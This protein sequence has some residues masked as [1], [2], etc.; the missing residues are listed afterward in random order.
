MTFVS[1][2]QECV[3]GLWG[4]FAWPELGFLTVGVLTGALVGI[5]PG[6]GGAATLAIFLPFSFSLPPTQMFALLLGVAA[7]ASTT[8]DLTSILVGIPGEATAAATVVDG[9]PMTL[10]GEAGR[11]IGASLVSSFTGSIVG[12]L[13]LA[14]MVPLALDVARAIGSPELFMLALL[15][16]SF[17]AAISP[18]T[19]LQG[20]AVGGLGLML[21]TVGL[22]RIGATPRFTFGQLFLWDGVGPI[23]VALGLLAIPEIVGM[24]SGFSA[25]PVTP[26]AAGSRLS[27]GTADARRLWP[28]VLQSSVIGTVI[29]LLPGVGAGV[30]QW[31]AYGYAAR[32]GT[33]GT[34]FG[35][36]AVEGV[37]APSAAN[38][39][40]LGAS[41][42]PALALGIPGGL[43]S[44]ILVG[45]LILKGL[46]PGP[47]M[48]LPSNQGGQLTLVFTLVWLIV[49]GNIIAVTLAYLSSKWL[50]K[51]AQVL[52]VTLVPVLLLLIFVGA[53][54]ERQAIEAL[55]VTALMGVLG[56]AMVRYRWPRAPLLLGVVLGPLVENR[57]F[58][59]MDA[60]GIE[61]LVRPGVLAIAALLVAG[62]TL[63]LWKSGQPR[64]VR[65]FTEVPGT[66]RAP[67]LGEAVFVMG[68]VAA[69]A[70]A[71][72]TAASYA[73]S[74]ALA[75][76]LIAAVTI[77]LLL[78]AFV[79]KHGR[80]SATLQGADPVVFTKASMLI[81]AWIPVYLLSVWGLGFLVGAPLAIFGHLALANRDPLPRSVVLAGSTWVFL[82]V[83]LGRLLGVAFPPGALFI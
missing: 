82:D 23:P 11:A 73:R 34:A 64:T 67:P 68:L 29:G 30:S 24:A 56:L 28:L 32:R 16:V 41:L 50:I 14:L 46:R 69:L 3:A 60:Y 79:V 66:R 7:V 31:V 48:L 59:S 45:A 61:W 35:K 58:L 36:G 55:F 74:A 22:D 71:F 12:A 13:T 25:S 81:V 19:R 78:V 21:A 76:R 80:R 43:M 5:L 65:P 8:G 26:P 20:L 49:I 2:L 54:M 72:T 47:S 51:L 63:P 9:R 42:V 75:P 37:I 40:T 33:S 77:V 53:F 57:L 1:A 17:I 6:L 44:A 70:A 83:V 38:N 10:R 62:L 18:E 4:V 52:A 39:A 15:G 27:E